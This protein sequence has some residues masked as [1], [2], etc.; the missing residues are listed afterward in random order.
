MAERLF[1]WVTEVP[2][3]DA[4]ER[5][6]ATLATGS[7]DAN[8]LLP[9]KLLPM[10][11]FASLTLFPGGT[12]AP[13]TGD[14]PTATLVFESNIDGSVGGYTRE[15]VGR[16]RKGLDRLYAGLKGYPAVDEPA[17]K[18]VEY[19]RKHA[20]FPQLYH[21]GHPDRSVLA[22]RGDH[23]LRRSIAHELP[24]LRHLSPKDIVKR[25]RAQARCPHWFVPFVRPWHPDWAGPPRNQPTPLNCIQ[26][27]A[28]A[29]PYLP[30]L[31]RG[32]GLALLASALEISLVVLAGRFLGTP[33]P[34]TLL[35]ASLLIAGIVHKSSADTRLVR[36]VVE[37]GI[38]AALVATFFKL[39]KFTDPS[40]PTS[41]LLAFSFIF[42]IPTVIIGASYITI[43]LQLKVTQPLPVFN[44]QQRQHIRELMDAEDRPEH[45]IYNHVTGLSVFKPDLIA[46]RRLRTWLVLKVLNLIY[47]TY[48][49][50]GKLVSIPSI[51]FAQWRLLDKGLL[52]LTNYD[53][54]ADSYLDDFFN[55]LA[56]GVAFIWHDTVTF[57]GTMDPRL[58]KLWVRKNQV[59]AA[60]R[61]RAL[62]YDDLTVGLIND[63]TYI[64]TRLLRGRGQ[65]SARRWLRRFATIPVEPTVLSRIAMRLKELA[66]IVD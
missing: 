46:F 57:P 61:Y 28:D 30:R 10:L 13:G 51:H 41:W 60:V 3:R 17:E 14:E 5:V 37:A 11:H 8:K 43:L 66:G 59:L 32:I 39:I 38:I 45:S 35:V 52:F 22:I 58:L 54:S 25:I 40:H 56:A 15:L 16:G 21:I 53:D 49:V 26:W 65:H 64:R 20:K 62:V 36:G 9:F 63:N 44:R 4:I 18:V 29:F 48:F 24:E 55:S 50:K 1:T 19:L 12:G 7:P 6:R 33:Q 34:A 47:R 31:L 27:V 42:M 23:E 2:G